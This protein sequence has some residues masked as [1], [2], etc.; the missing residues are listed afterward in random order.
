MVDLSENQK[1]QVEQMKK[2]AQEAP[3]HVPARALLNEAW[4]VYEEQALR[5]KMQEGQLD[6]GM[7]SPEEW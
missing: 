3:K 6:G 1:Y 2:W 7:W 4:R 5:L